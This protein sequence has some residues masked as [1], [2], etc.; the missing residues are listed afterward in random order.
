MSWPAANDPMYL[1]NPG[2]NNARR[3]VY[4]VN[5]IPY[6]AIDGNRFTGNVNNVNS[7]I[8]IVQ[9]AYDNAPSSFE[10][11]LNYQLNDSENQLL[12]T[13][14]ITAVEPVENLD[15]NLFLAVIEKH[16]HLPNPQPNGEQ[17]FY[18]VLKALVPSSGGTSL[19]ATWEEND[20]ITVQFTWDVFGFYD[21]NEI[22]LIGF[23]QTNGSSHAVEQSGYGTNENFAPNYN[24]DMAVLDI[25]T[26][27]VLCNN[28]VSPKITIRNQGV[29]PITSAVIKYSVNGGEESIYNWSG[30]LNLL[31][32]EIVELNPISFDTES[33]YNIS[34]IIENPN[35]TTDEYVKNNTLSVNIAQSAYMPQ[36]CKV[37]ILTDG[38]PEETTWD[39]KNSAGEIIAS[40][41]PY[42]MTSIFLEPFEWTGNDCFTFTIYDAGGNGLDGGFYKIVNSSTQVIW[43]G[44][45][46]FKF[47]TS[48]EFAFDDV[49]K[50]DLVPALGEIKVYPNP[51]FDKSNIEFTLPEQSIVH[52]GV[53]NIIG[54]KV[55]EVYRGALS[56]GNN[57]FDLNTEGLESGVY[58]VHL[59]INGQVTTEKIH[60][61]K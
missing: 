26:P 20:Y 9:N 40:G 19:P 35:N 8:N 50:L 57:K 60:I 13:A 52:L 36:N 6:A 11:Q 53:Y 27:Q 28:S 22:G 2:D 5:S 4:G 54:K 21:I 34:V 37:A 56:A 41:G 23:I 46:D 12:V 55:I 10:L 14:M 42:S 17:D 38:N 31:E 44:T 18:N 7:L 3:G 45:N 39:I 15:A 48:A 30:N 58:F 43:Q 61:I 32:S 33:S 16:I 1:N 49:M 59:E 24:V 25:E 51:I 29:D 47:A